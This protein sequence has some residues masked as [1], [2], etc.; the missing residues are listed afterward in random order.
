MK[1]IFTKTF[2]KSLLKIDKNLQIRIIDK[3]EEFISWEENLDIK[4]L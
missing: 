3:I 2:E 4:K 1:V